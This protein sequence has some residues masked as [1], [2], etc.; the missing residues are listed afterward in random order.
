ML[1]VFAMCL[2]YFF[3]RISLSQ[4]AFAL[5]APTAEYIMLTRKTYSD[6]PITRSVGYFGIMEYSG[7]DGKTLLE[8]YK[9]EPLFLQKI[10][11]SRLALKSD[12]PENRKILEEIYSISDDEMKR[13][14]NENTPGFMRK[15]GN[16][17]MNRNPSLKL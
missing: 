9:T 16:Y 10:I 15:T 2:G 8:K 13:H 1:L 5:F 3:S 6:D 14:M 4:E 7:F 12:R 11:I 17:I